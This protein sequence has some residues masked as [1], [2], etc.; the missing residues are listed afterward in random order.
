M[1]RTLI[2]MFFSLGFETV[3]YANEPTRPNPRNEDNLRLL[4]EGFSINRDAFPFLT[5]RFQH[6]EGTAVD[7]EAALRGELTNPIVSDLLWIVNGAKVKH[8]ITCAAP[9]DIADEK[10]VSGKP[11][12]RS[13]LCSAKGVLYDGK[14]VFRW[15]GI[16]NAANIYARETAVPEI[17][18]TPFGMGIMGPDDK[19]NT[20]NVLRR[21]IAGEL[22]AVFDGPEV[23]G[24]L[25]LTRIRLGPTKDRLVATEWIDSKRG[26][27]P[28]RIET[29]VSPKGSMLYLAIVKKVKECSNGRWFPTYSIVVDNPERETGQL[30]T[31]VFKVVDLDVD[32]EP[33]NEVFFI[34]VSAGAQISEQ[35]AN[36]SPAF[37]TLGKDERIS[38]NDLGNVL[39]RCRAKI[40]YW[41]KIIQ[42][43]K[44][45]PSGGSSQNSYKLWFVRINVAILFFVGALIYRKRLSAF[46][47]RKE[48]TQ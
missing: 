37:F 33:K 25:Q 40:P 15:S 6:L 48:K 8:Q 14:H 23:V 18:E 42:Q 34:D 36:G 26:F 35:S 4:A 39:E 43:G 10:E 20:A 38:V 16:A 45:P 11:G 17:F 12:M 30:R 19:N 21:C 13:D 1:L 28:V 2:L 41:N 27:L 44:Q 29:R 9:Q 22:Y 46:F 3:V 5:C 7:L 31:Q 24:G 47:F 32:N